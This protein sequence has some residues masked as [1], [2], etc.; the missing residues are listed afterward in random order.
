M[1]NRTINLI[2]AHFQQSN[3]FKHLP[4]FDRIH[5]LGHPDE[6]VQL[7]KAIRE[8]QE[9][10]LLALTIIRREEDFLWA[11]AEDLLDR[12]V[13]EAAA[14]VSGIYTFDLLTFDI[15]T[16]VDTFNY[17]EFG[18][19]IANHSRKIQPGEQRL[20]KYSSA[21]G[22]L[23]KLIIE[24]W[25]KITF[26]TSVEVYKDKPS[27]FYLLVKRLFKTN[28]ENRHA[29]SL[30]CNPLVLLINDVS[31]DPIYNPDDQG[32]QE[33][34]AKTIAEH[35]KETIEFLPEVYVKNKNGVWELT[36]GSVILE[37]KDKE[38]TR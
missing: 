8:D 15:H 27:L 22:I 32:Q 16:E 10:T 35:S 5:Y 7:Y 25:G 37:F 29:C 6:K 1:V 4:V 31:R 13:K 18:L 38:V 23:Q 2:D 12:C 17:N 3:L 34:L 9:C 28:V 30:H 19:L 20:V 21:Y 24:P 14:R 11:A 26:K 36:S 33:F